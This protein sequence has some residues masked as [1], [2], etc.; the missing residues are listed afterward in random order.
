V[1]YLVDNGA[2]GRN[3]ALMLA[4]GKGHID[5]VKCL[6]DNGADVNASSGVRIVGQSIFL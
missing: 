4:A 6:V 2:V 1:K 5:V 3:S